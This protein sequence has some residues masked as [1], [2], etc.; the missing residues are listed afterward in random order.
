MVAYR[1]DGEVSAEVVNPVLGQV[2]RRASTRAVL[3]IAW[4]GG[5]LRA[6]DVME[7]SGL[8][9]ST[10]LQA[11]DALSELG[12]IEEASTREGER[13]KGRPAR[14]FRLRS[15]AGAIVGLEAGQ[16]TM[17]VTVTDLMGAVRA[18][19]SVDIPNA[20]PSHQQDPVQRRLL[21]R[22]AVEEALRDAGVGV[23]DVVVVGIGVPAPV[24][25][26][27][28]S[29]H[30][31]QGFWK[32]M[33]A[34]LAEMFQQEFAHVRIE[35]DA[36]LAALAELHFGA[37]KQE[38][39]FVTL[40]AA[41]GIGAGVVLDGRLVRGV[42]GAV[43]ELG[44]FERV[45][46]VGSSVGFHEFIEDWVRTNWREED[47]PGGHPWQ[48]Y[49]RGERPRE[50]LLALLGEQDLVMAPLFRE[51]VLRIGRI[52]EFLALVYD[53]AVI[54]VAGPVARDVAPVLEAVRRELAATSGLGALKVVAS[55]LGG[56]LVS[57]GAAAAA[58]EMS[59]ASVIEW[60][61]EKQAD[62]AERS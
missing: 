10:V 8:T 31:W 53:P 32:V 34:G 54:I 49:L 14:R 1:N 41:W 29:P 27:G 40:L 11:L 15:Q 5:V 3:E 18:S 23:G 39:N 55:P 6:D 25:E 42:N 58:R 28:R 48:E 7:R 24:D 26:H 30:G 19:R 36:V 43:G 38:R 46:G 44:F 60:A 33:H 35:N 45:K 9:R 52:L 62:E 59:M 51:L 56:D 57:L 47:L 20:E 37:A 12:L 22:A 61:L 50:S 17:T 13:G 16:R 21:A 2:C 4:E